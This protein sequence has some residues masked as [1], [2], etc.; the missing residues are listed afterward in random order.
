VGQL[1]VRNVEDDIIRT[2]KVRA[3]AKGRSAEAEHRDILRDALTVPR[4]GKTL[5]DLLLCMPEDGTDADF[6][7][8]RD[9]GRKIRW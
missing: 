4:K 6:E 7:R 9:S 1:I 8:P 2:L 3:A 5:K